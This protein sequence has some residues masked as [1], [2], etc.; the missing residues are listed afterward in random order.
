MN[1]SQ[2]AGPGAAPSIRVLPDL[3][4]S[5]IAAGE[6][7]ERPASVLKELLEN[8]LDAGAREIQVT[9]D[10]GGAKRVQVDDDGAGLAQDDL[11][12][13]LARHA[14]SKIRTLEDLQG[15]ASM[16]FRGEALASIASVARLSIIT[17]PKSAARASTI[18]S[19]SG[20]A[21]LPAPA[22]RAPGTTVLVEDLYFNTP[23][24]KKFLRTEQTEFG[25]CDQVFRRI[26][27][28]R[29][30]VAFTLKHN[31][32]V[33]A[34]LRAQT[35][36]ERAAALLGRE[37]LEASFTVEAQAGSL[38]LYGLA[39]TP[40]A[41]RA[42]ADAQYLFV[43]G[44]FVRDRMLAHAVREAYRD[45]LHGERQ[46][47]YLLFL[48]IDPR[49][50]DVNVHPAKIEVRFRDAGAIHQ[51]VLHA[52][53]RAL[54]PAAGEAPVVYARPAASGS[55]MQPDFQLAQPAQA[56]Q[57]FMSAAIAGALPVSEKS[58]P[59]DEGAPRVPP[60]GFALAQLHGVYILAQNEAG[61]VLVDMHAAHERVVMEQLKKS[62]D[63]GA[64]ARQSLLVP[65][66]LVA[67][68]LEIA[69][70]EEN[71]DA[72][73]R[74]GLETSISG[75]NELAVRAAPA[76]LAGGDIAGLTRNLLRDIREYGASEVLSA[77]QNELLATMACHA[78]VRANRA[79]TQTEMNALLREME[80]TERS[81]SCNH[82]RPTWYQLTMA[83]LDRLFLRGQ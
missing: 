43:N 35:L 24:R 80:E 27:L 75:P 81:G 15:V 78:A 5:Q 50:V 17:R 55:G 76:L 11:P 26:A 51:F 10:Q 66:V 1:A 82:G 62:L 45:Q 54:S 18:R 14:T 8:A 42:R 4:I 53:K 19:E 25:H 20:S 60:L 44:R 57:T 38:R 30:D 52:L 73:E 48:E 49:G 64:V 6:V 68:A 83:D 46:P 41:A 33:A 23:A 2:G 70:A 71:G 7:V 36:G 13:A 3:L 28:A 34:L 72:L 77:R 65:A 32:R 21:A 74:L 56:Y 39:G 59:L 29:P 69:T 40:Q 47:A 67:D 9:L 63:A 12:L 37:L 16:G 22:A 31:G 79:L 58:P 61:L